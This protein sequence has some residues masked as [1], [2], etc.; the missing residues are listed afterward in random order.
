MPQEGK[1]SEGSCRTHTHTHQE[2][3]KVDN[4]NMR[5]PSS[6]PCQKRPDQLLPDGQ[7]GDVQL[8]QAPSRVLKRAVS[9]LERVK[10]TFADRPEVY[11]SF[12]AVMHAFKEQRIDI[13]GLVT[14]VY[15]LFEGYPNLLIGFNTFLPIGH[16]P[17][18]PAGPPAANNDAGT[19]GTTSSVLEPSV[20]PV[21]ERQ[22]TVV[23]SNGV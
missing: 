8:Q 18:K 19:S 11:R 3:K 20:P 7:Q 22:Q 9:Y 1:L 21:S 23:V 17:W 13:A 2:K 5:Q 12:L 16:A 15:H 6:V 14:Q 4:N 10:R